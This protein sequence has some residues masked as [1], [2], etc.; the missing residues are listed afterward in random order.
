MHLTIATKTREPQAWR[1]VVDE[2]F[3]AVTAG[4]GAAGV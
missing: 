3:S 4:P 2:V 1:G